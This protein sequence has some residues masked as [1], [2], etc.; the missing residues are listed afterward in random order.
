VSTV[1]TGGQHCTPQH[2]T[3]R[4]LNLYSLLP[5]SAPLTCPSAAVPLVLPVNNTRGHHSTAHHTTIRN[6]NLYSLLPGRA[7]WTSRVAAAPLVLPVTQHKGTTQHS[8]TTPCNPKPE[9]WS[10]TLKLR[11]LC[12]PGSAPWTCRAAAVPLVSPVRTGGPGCCS[13][14]S[15]AGW[16]WAGTG[17]SCCHRCWRLHLQGTRCSNLQGK[18]QQDARHLSDEERVTL[19][20]TKEVLS[21]AKAG[22][23]PKKQRPNTDYL[24]L[25]HSQMKQTPYSAR[26]Q[27][28]NQAAHEC[29]W[30]Q[31]WQHNGERA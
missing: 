7:P 22:S 16:C 25:V 26:T 5:G 23:T 13:H 4:N 6:L 31:I 20:A 21:Q 30:F 18:Q 28:T 19:Q 2:T 29:S 14:G 27:P 17:S 24:N 3:I 10:L 15:W 11:P 1:K 9:H 8:T 12:L